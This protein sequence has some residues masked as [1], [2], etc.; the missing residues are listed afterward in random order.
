MNATDNKKFWYYNILG[1]ALSFTGFFFFP[2]LSPYIKDALQ[3]MPLYGLPIEVWLGII[4]A[5]SSASIILGVHALGALAD[6]IG[7]KPVILIGI[8]SLI[9]GLIFYLIGSHPIAFVLARIFDSLGYTS[10]IIIML[11]RVND[12]TD[13][14]ERGLKQGIFLSMQQLGPMI[15]PLVG[16][17]VASYF[18]PEAIFLASIII[19]IILGSLLL[20][21]T[22]KKS[23]HI[24]KNHINIIKNWK[25][26]LTFKPLKGMAILGMA[27]HSHSPIISIFLSLLILERFPGQYAFIGYAFFALHALRPLQFIFG[28]VVDKYGKKRFTIIGCLIVA[29]GLFLIPITTSFLSLIMVLIIIAIGNN[30]WNVGAWTVMS[31]IGEANKIEGHVAGTYS[32]IAKIGDLGSTLAFGGLAAAFGT[33]ITF[34][35]SGY[36]IITGILI[37]I[38]FLKD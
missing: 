17:W 19:L 10:A 18:F 1:A 36:I 4:F 16:A 33:A 34:T 13:N 29:C 23:F 12:L 11:A 30:F 28:K 9:I 3:T 6:D 26:F 27:M 20:T 8:V 38:F 7:R 37:S 21:K 32:S 15:A 25:E 5:A 35:I 14:K 31:D 22:H 24:T 2:F